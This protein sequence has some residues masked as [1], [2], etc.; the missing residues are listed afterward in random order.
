MLRNSPTIGR[1]RWVKARTDKHYKGRTNSRRG[2][3]EFV[4]NDNKLLMFGANKVKWITKR[5]MGSGVT[6]IKCVKDSEKK[7]LGRE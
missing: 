4:G 1:V 2:G 5:K 6:I 3:R 7:F